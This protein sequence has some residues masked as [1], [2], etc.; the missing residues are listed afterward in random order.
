MNSQE[1]NDHIESILFQLIEHDKAG[2]WY[3]ME[4][5]APNVEHAADQLMYLTTKLIELGL[6]QEDAYKSFLSP[7]NLARDIV[8]HDGGWLSYLKRKSEEADKHR[9]A[10]KQKNIEESQR[11]Q[12]ENERAE[13]TLTIGKKSAVASKQS[14]IAAWAA[15]AVAILALGFGMFQHFSANRDLTDVD[16]NLGKRLDSLTQV[17]QSI[18]SKQSM[19]LP[20]QRQ[21]TLQTDSVP[22][23]KKIRSK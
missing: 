2:T 23:V 16:R 14:A 7:T 20:D 3:R 21:T 22:I 9:E 1:T 5:Y 13:E 12:R 19:Q 11:L 18:Q 15:T 6:A 17:I 10:E 4:Q 8:S